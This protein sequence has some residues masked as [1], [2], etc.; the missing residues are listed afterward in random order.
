M[1]ARVASGW[2][3]IGR[4]AEVTQATAN[5]VEKIGDTSALEF[6][7]RYIG[8]N[9]SPTGEYPIAVFEPGRDSF[10]LRAPLHADP[11]TGAVT[12]YGDVPLGATVQLT[13]TKPDDVVTACAASVRQAAAAYPGTTPLV[14][15][16]ISCAGRRHILGSRTVEEFTAVR[17]GLAK[18]VQ[19]AGFY[20]YGEIGP[21]G[22]ERP[23]Q[24]HNETFVT[25]L[26]GEQ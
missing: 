14:A 25:L 15:L 16:C 17:S 7:R 3:P 5:K 12:F 21:T 6:Y 18:D 22:P 24:L 1:F 13:Q 8:R 26:L 4:S 23:A 20:A 11:E 19:I 10:Y 2:T 9:N